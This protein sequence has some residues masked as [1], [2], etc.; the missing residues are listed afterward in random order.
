MVTTITV[1]ITR[2]TMMTETRATTTMIE[3]TMTMVTT[4]MMVVTTTMV[5]MAHCNKIVSLL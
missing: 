4:T 3:V 2:G 1:A 5:R